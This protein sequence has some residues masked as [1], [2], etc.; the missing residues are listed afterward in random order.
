GTAGYTGDGVEPFGGDGT[1]AAT[2]FTYKVKYTDVNG[3]APIK[4]FCRIS[5]LDCDGKWKVHKNIKLQPEAGGSYTTGKIYAGGTTLPNEVWNYKFVFADGD[6]NATGP[7]TRNSQGPRI[8]GPPQLCW[9]GAT[10]YGGVDG[11]NPNSGP[12]GT[13]FRFRVVY[14]DSFGAS[15]PS[16]FNVEIRRD[17]KIVETR[18][19]NRKGGDDR[20]GRVYA[21]KIRLKRPLTNYQYRFVFADVGGPATGDPT[22]WTSGLDTTASDGVLALTGVSAAQTSVGA[23]LN[24]TLSS[25]ADVTAT[26]INVAG[27]PVRTIITDSPMDQG[28]NTLLWDRRDENGLNVPSGLYMIRVDARDPGGA[29]TSGMATVPLR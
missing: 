27:R 25:A 7:P 6:G 12:P 28:I 4:R 24:F 15:P 23:Q 14:R 19:M 20:L 26:V 2:T 9:S 11:V 17:G 5:R 21:R 1:T 8:N 18:A 16:T 22:A 29:Q 3:D 10:G 13:P